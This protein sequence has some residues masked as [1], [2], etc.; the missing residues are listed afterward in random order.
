[1]KNSSKTIGIA[2][3]VAVGAYF[4]L[5]RRSTQAPAPPANYPP[6]PPRNNAQAWAQWASQM[7]SLFGQSAALF[8]PGGPFYRVKPEEVND[9]INTYVNPYEMGGGGQGGWV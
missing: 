2:L 3:L 6:A 9:A 1:M 8:Q 5:S 4:L 7:I